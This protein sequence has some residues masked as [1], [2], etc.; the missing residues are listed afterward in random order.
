VGEGWD[1]ARAA[2]LAL[3]AG[4]IACP[5]LSA[6]RAAVVSNRDTK[7]WSTREAAQT[8]VT[9]ELSLSFPM[10]FQTSPSNCI[11]IFFLHS[12]ATICVMFHTISV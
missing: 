3:A 5:Q 8:D 4:E 11:C 7:S 6:S 1:V 2:F 9:T 10:Q 12:Y